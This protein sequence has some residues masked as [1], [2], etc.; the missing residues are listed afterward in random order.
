MV[1]PD[2]K[3]LASLWGGQ[4][5]DLWNRLIDH[6]EVVLKQKRKKSRSSNASPT[7]VNEPIPSPPPFIEET[8]TT[9]RVTM[10]LGNVGPD[11]I[12]VNIQPGSTGH[13]LTVTAVCG[14]GEKNSSGGTSVK[15][16][17]FL[18]ITASLSDLDTD[19]IDG[20]LLLTFP[21]VENDELSAP[22]MVGCDDNRKRKV[23]CPEDEE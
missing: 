12:D 3:V 10:N 5:F 6:H 14:V 13:F 20:S 17:V 4:S 15:H 9:F 21:K 19:F 1:A 2:D 11:G 22:C 16:S 18:P 23:D 7:T 8:D